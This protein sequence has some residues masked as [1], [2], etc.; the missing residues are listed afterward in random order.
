MAVDAN[1][2]CLIAVAGEI[3][4]G[5]STIAAEVS[6]RL[7]IPVHSIDEDKWFVGASWPDFEQWIA[8]GVPFPDEFNHE[9]FGRTLA[10]LRELAVPGATLIVEE[11]FQ[12]KNLRDPFFDSARELFGRMY[13]VE[14]VVDEEVALA[15]LERRA[16]NES[17]HM[18][19]RRM[20]ETLRRLAD[21]LENVDLVV[22]NNGELSLAVN[23]VCRHLNAFLDLPCD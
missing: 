17:G 19:G 5:K 7:A 23:E 13:L 21:P 20:Y 1:T 9:V 15:H 6:R 11:S 18:A 8:D 16:R 10:Q 2:G 4:A 22:D 3:G 14:I 12:R